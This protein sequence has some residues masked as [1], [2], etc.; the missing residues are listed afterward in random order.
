MKIKTLLIALSVS[1]PLA[2]LAA[3]NPTEG[4]KKAETCKACHGE[5]GAKPIQ[6][7]YPVLA[8]QHSDYLVAALN[9]Y[10]SGK[11]KNASMNGFAAALKPQDIEDLAAYFASQPSDLKMK[12]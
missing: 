11:R 1:L 12:Y 9:Q 7:D 2:A 8:G 10:K 6:P 5:G 4:A 3:G